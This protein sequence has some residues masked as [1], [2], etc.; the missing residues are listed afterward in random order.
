MCVLIC[1]VLDL[2][3][4]DTLGFFILGGYSLSH[5]RE[6]FNHYLL[7]HFLMPFPFVYFLHE[8]YYLNIGSFNIFPELSEAVLISLFIFFPCSASFISN[9]VSSSSLS[10]SSTWVTLLFF[11]SRVISISVIALLIIEYSLF[12]LG[13]FKTP[14]ASS[15]SMSKVYLS[16]ALFVSKILTI[17]MLNC[18]PC[19]LPTSSCFNGLL[20]FIVFLHLL[21]ISLPFYVV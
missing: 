8:T 20:V 13:P 15:H 1:F 4:R 5:F 12:L 19:R 6:V 16:E 14:L 21:D 3:L 17:I 11:L 9:I 7:K 10:L 2:S 18:C